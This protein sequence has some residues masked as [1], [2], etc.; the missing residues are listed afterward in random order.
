MGNVNASGDLK[1][2]RA[3]GNGP[4]GVSGSESNKQH[5]GHLIGGF[6]ALPRAAVI[7]LESGTS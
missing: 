6:T 3:S 2:S 5:Q 4:L 7:R 1:T